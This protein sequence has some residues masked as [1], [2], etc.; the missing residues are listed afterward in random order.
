MPI[1]LTPPDST[2]IWRCLPHCQSATY[3]P[4][5]CAFKL[6]VCVALQLHTSRPSPYTALPQWHKVVLLPICPLSLAWCME[7]C[8]YL[9]QCNDWPWA[10]C[11]YVQWIDIRNSSLFKV[12]SVF[13]KSQAVQTWVNVRVSFFTLTRLGEWLLAY[14]DEILTWCGRLE[15]RNR[16]DFNPQYLL[17]CWE[18]VWAAWLIR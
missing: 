11:G 18:L 8:G 3:L 17:H 16:A 10:D 1:A 2:I 12:C 9:V 15:T 13:C 5:V 7:S 4:S 14:I 6:C